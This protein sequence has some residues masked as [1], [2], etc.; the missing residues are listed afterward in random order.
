MEANLQSIFLRVLRKQ[1]TAKITLAQIYVSIVTQHNILHSF[2]VSRMHCK[3]KTVLT[4]EKTQTKPV[5]I[6]TATQM[7]VMQSMMANIKLQHR[8][9]SY[10]VNQPLLSYLVVGPKFPLCSLVSH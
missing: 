7:K 9:T 6:E 2:L 1:K 5:R 4:A 10:E 3:L 8:R